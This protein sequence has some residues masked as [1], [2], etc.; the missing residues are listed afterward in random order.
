MYILITVFLTSAFLGPILT[1]PLCIYSF[2][3]SH[4]KRTGF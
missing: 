1:P 2:D 4:E 3:V